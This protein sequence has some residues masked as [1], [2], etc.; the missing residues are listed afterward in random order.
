MKIILD[1]KDSYNNYH[2]NNE[3]ELRDYINYMVETL[4]NFHNA[5]NDDE[6]TQRNEKKF[7]RIQNDE[8]IMNK[9]ATELGKMKLADMQDIN[10]EISKLLDKESE[11]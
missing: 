9:L 11:E 4:W 6:L 3:I 10:Y 5:L 8:N 2:W 7:R 1:L